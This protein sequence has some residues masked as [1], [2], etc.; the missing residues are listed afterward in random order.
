M[1]GSRSGAGKVNKPYNKEESKKIEAQKTAQ[2]NSMVS[3]YQKQA[4]E[5]K[6]HFANNKAG[7]F[8]YTDKEGIIWQTTKNPDGS[9]TKTQIGTVKKSIVPT[10]P[11]PPPPPTPPSAATTWGGRP[12]PVPS[13]P[14]PSIRSTITQSTNVQFTPPPQ[15]P[16]GFGSV[17]GQAPP[18]NFGY[19]GNRRPPPQPFIPQP[20]S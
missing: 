11:A 3:G 20:R 14:N 8:T 19:L 12:P 16:Q 15:R 9:Q 18:G 6:L 1:A 5:G 2:W 4:N 7:T 17:V 10:R 13:R